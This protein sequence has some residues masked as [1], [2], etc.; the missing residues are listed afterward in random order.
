MTSPVWKPCSAAGPS[1]STA[2]TTTPLLPEPATSVEIEALLDNGKEHYTEEFASLTTLAAKE[3][4]AIEHD[5]AVGH[6]AE[7]IVRKAEDIH[8]DLIVM[9]SRGLTRATRWLLGSVS[10]RVL[11]Y[12]HCPVTVVK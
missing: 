12:A 6:P 11:R 7:H 1:G 4:I 5:V 8:A 2:V 3:G 10:E 9:G